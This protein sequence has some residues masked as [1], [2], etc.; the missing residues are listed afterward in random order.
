MAGPRKTPMALPP[1]LCD[2]FIS[3]VLRHHEAPTTLIICSS[4]EAFLAELQTNIQ[5][6]YRES[7][8]ASSNDGVPISLHPLLIPTI[9]LIAKSRSVNLVFVPTLPH[10]RAYLTTCAAPLN[11]VSSPSPPT[12]PGSQV[13]IL[14]IWGLARLHR[15]TAERSAQGLSRTVAAAVEAA[16]QAKQRLVLAEPSRTDDGNNYSDAEASDRVSGDAW[17]EHVPLLSGSVR[18]GGEDRAWAGKTIE[19]GRVV[20]KWCRFV[21]LD[22][23]ASDM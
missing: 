21:K 22:Y 5:Q 15:S 9:H 18:F 6:G 14:A 23:E 8:P 20:A 10:L 12:K 17:K 3:F 11:P 13:P 7:P 4:R 2:D 16:S 1:V 19:V